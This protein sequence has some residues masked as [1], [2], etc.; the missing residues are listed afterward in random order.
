MSEMTQGIIQNIF[1]ITGITI[2]TDTCYMMVN[3]H[4]CYCPVYLMMVGT[5]PILVTR[6]PQDPAQ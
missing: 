1:F 4:L 3:A 5:V 2:C 6:L